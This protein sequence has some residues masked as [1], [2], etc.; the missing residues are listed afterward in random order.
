VVV[1]LFAV[2]VVQQEHQVLALVVL[3]EQEI[4]L[5]VAQ[6]HQEQEQASAVAAV[7]QDLHL[8]AQTLLPTMAVTVAQVV[9]VGAR[10]LLVALLVQAVTALYFFITKE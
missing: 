2:A 8:L 7:V 5:L 1:E 9:V 10:L 4:S 3:V 6:V